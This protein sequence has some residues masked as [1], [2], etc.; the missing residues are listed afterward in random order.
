MRPASDEL[1]LSFHCMPDLLKNQGLNCA[2]KAHINKATLTLRYLPLFPLYPTA[3]ALGL[4][5]LHR[6]P[7]LRLSSLTQPFPKPFRSLCRH[8]APRIEKLN[9]GPPQSRSTCSPQLLFPCAM[10]RLLKFQIT[11]ENTLK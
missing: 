9:D 1:Y 2:P 11:K 4:V 6:H 8:Q 5:S 10:K 7:H 3:L